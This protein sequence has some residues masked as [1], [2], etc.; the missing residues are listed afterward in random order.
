MC[1]H[2]RATQRR[3]N[4]QEIWEAG[5]EGRRRIREQ[6]GKGWWILGAREGCQE[7]LGVRADTQG[8]RSRPQE[9]LEEG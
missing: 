3:E 8:R 4:R 6:G 5:P 1:L 2:L 9:A 7:Q